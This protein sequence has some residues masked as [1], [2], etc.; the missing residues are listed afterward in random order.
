V[1]I[2]KSLKGGTHVFAVVAN[3]ERTIPAPKNLLGVG[4]KLGA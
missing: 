1:A 4:C 3:S 2:R